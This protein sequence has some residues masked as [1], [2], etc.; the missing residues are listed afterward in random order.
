MG[1]LLKETVE[2][3]EYLELNV[4]DI[5]FIGSL[6]S[7]HSCT[8]EEFKV[9]ADRVYDAGFGAQEVASDLVIIF[10]GGERL[11]RSEYDGAEGWDCT[12]IPIIPED[13]K[14]IK[15][16]FAVGVGWERLEKIEKRL[17][18]VS[19][20]MVGRKIGEAYFIGAGSKN[21]T[22]KLHPQLQSDLEGFVYVS[23]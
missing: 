11:Y 8:W 17:E 22:S 23:K 20:G 3:L 15:S 7:G 1:N 12:R 13:Q 9:L 14:E 4:D 19:E 5:I 16:L 10:K 6:E 21:G 2:D 18:R